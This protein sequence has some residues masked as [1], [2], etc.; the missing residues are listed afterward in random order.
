MRYLKKIAK[1]RFDATSLTVPKLRPKI[2]KTI[3]NHRKGSKTENLQKVFVYRGNPLFSALSLLPL[4]PTHGR[5]QRF[6]SSIAH[7]AF[8]GMLTKP[9]FLREGRGGQ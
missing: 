2:S 8:P 3:K 7:H 1:A 9:P 4:L 6:K 5:G